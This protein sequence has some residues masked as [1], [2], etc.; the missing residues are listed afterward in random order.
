MGVLGAARR[1]LA[2]LL[3]SGPK[4]WTTGFF[5][6]YL[7][8]A[9]L[10][11]FPVFLI[12]RS[13]T[14]EVE[15]SRFVAAAEQAANRLA[16]EIDLTLANLRALKG[17]YDGSVH[18]TREEFRAFIHALRPRQAVQSLEWIPRVQAAARQDLERTAHEDGFADF[19]FR[20]HNVEGTSIPATK[21]V[22][23][24]PVYYLE[25]FAGNEAMFGLDLGAD[26]ISLD[27]LRRARD[28]GDQTASGRVKLG[29]GPD[30]QYGILVFEPIY[31][32][33]ALSLDAR[34]E[35]LEG[36]ARGV[37]RVT[38]LI[39]MAVPEDQF[40][41]TVLDLSAPLGE[42][43]IYPAV[44]IEES[45]P[46]RHAVTLNIA[47][48]D[49][50]VRLA[51]ASA[52][53]LT[54]LPWFAA[55]TWFGALVVFWT[56]RELVSSRR[57]SQQLA[58]V[59]LRLE[60]LSNQ[61][62]QAIKELERSNRELDDFAYIASHDLKEPLRAVYNHASFLLE[63]YEERLAEDGQQRLRRLVVLSQRME[64][65]IADLL[66]FSRLGRGELAVESVDL[67]LVITDIEAQ[68]AEALQ[69][70]NAKI[71]VGKRLP[72]VQGHRPHMTAIFQ[73]LISNGIKY[74][75]S[76][77][78]IIEIGVMPAERKSQWATFDTFYIRDNGI[79]IDEQFKD[80]VFRIFKRLNSE[81]AYGEGTGAGLSFVKKIVESH[82]G[83]IWLTSKAG[84][85]TTFFF[86]LKR[87]S[88]QMLVESGLRAA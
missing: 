8:L 64:K 13:L 28:S 40:R 63:D 86:T 60:A 38:D 5:W 3:S 70:Q 48:R 10:S 30:D 9:V 76:E 2:T 56:L 47:D 33:V 45:R 35:Q 66:Y 7:G 85:G 84:E 31:T 44:D 83:S 34:I 51:P 21:R 68:L 79:G 20:E 23:Y 37:F 77:E 72:E 6:F 29:Q 58:V 65:L 1:R 22:E 41:V 18:V 36:F 39:R 52:S 42:R 81:K 50:S 74:N 57:H 61:R 82:G 69:R 71:V 32:E 12:T 73:N 16:H 55:A 14:E 80:D 43:Q 11:A 17:F 19:Q 26:P 67:N 62:Q 75:D 46:F 88:Q 53:A 87:S 54:T 25:P 49:W 78:K 27:A 59:N 24:F 15:H 4:G